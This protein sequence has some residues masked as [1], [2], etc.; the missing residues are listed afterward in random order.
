[1]SD[2]RIKLP[3]DKEILS[4]LENKSKTAEDV[5]LEVSTEAERVRKGAYGKD[6]NI[7][8]GTPL[9]DPYDKLA[10]Q[11]GQNQ[12]IDMDFG[13]DLAEA[14]GTI[15]PPSAYDVLTSAANNVKA[16]EEVYDLAGGEKSMVRA[17]RA[18]NAIHGTHLTTAQGWH[19]MQLVKN[20]KFFAKDQFHRG[21]GEDGAAYGAL[22][23]EARAMEV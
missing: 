18:F 3:S 16:R 4:E 1:M 23:T 9:A 13:V 10:K 8:N 17:V 15:S 19:F 21:S 20:A 7:V 11:I 22:M 14:V 6:S 12:G 5:L 2:E